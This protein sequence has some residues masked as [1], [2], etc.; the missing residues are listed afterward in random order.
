ML[1]D[2]E[3]DGSTMDMLKEKIKQ[4]IEV[5]VQSK[6]CLCIGFFRTMELI[7]DGNSE[8]KKIRFLTSV[9][10]IKL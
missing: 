10:P 1:K 3:K 2:P 8:Q 6:F 7:L 9:D 5:S 4:Q